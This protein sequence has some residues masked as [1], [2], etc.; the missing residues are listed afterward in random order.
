[1]LRKPWLL[2]LLFALVTGIL[3][4][5]LWFTVI[6][7]WQASTEKNTSIISQATQLAQNIGA[8]Q[9][10]WKLLTPSPTLPSASPTPAPNFQVYTVVEGDNPST[11]AEQF[12]ISLDDLLAANP[13]IAPESLFPGDTLIIPG[14]GY[15]PAMTATPA[16]LEP[17]P[18]ESDVPMALVSEDG[19]GL[20]LRETPGTDGI[21][22]TFLE[23][24]TPL[25]LIGRTADEAWLEVTTPTGLQGWVSAE[26]VEVNV[27]LAKVPVS[28]C[29]LASAS[30][31]PTTDA[32]GTP[33]PSEEP[34]S[35]VRQ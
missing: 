34:T 21:V 8:T 1:M 29:S 22:I 4:P 6:A 27:S 5:V 16:T 28:G 19:E 15:V 24:S 32:T 18:P 30:P 31:C 13:G 3:V 33:T 25:K 23:A 10:V 35:G 7:P 17:T 9:T 11:I 14:A 26:H 20:R 12:E 2:L